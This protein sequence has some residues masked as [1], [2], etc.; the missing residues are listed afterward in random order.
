M[1]KQEVSSA[2]GSHQSKFQKEEKE[3]KRIK[4]KNAF[5]DENY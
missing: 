4:P 5:R 3:K 1:N 2:C